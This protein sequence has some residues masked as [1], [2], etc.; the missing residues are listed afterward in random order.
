[1][2]LT[3]YYYFRFGGLDGFSGGKRLVSFDTTVDTV[4]D[5]AKLGITGLN[6][7][8]A[9]DALTHAALV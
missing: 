4:G 3:R 5:W 8:G 1:M 2:V 7:H 9:I 6:D